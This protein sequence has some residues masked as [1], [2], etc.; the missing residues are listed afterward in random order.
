MKAS[1][2][3]VSAFLLVVLTK[4]TEAQ[5]LHAATGMELLRQCDP[6][7]TD[8]GARTLDKLLCLTYLD[9][10]IQGHRTTTD[11]LKPAK[12]LLCFP[13]E[14]IEVEQ[15]Q[16]V[17]VKWLRE[18]PKDLHHSTRILVISALTQAF[19]CAVS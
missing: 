16:L 7:S 13:A 17:V 11:L 1:I 6:R 18:H 19:P 14:G 9:G 3:L 15:A 5:T 8:E 12:P 4:S 10:F 2:Y